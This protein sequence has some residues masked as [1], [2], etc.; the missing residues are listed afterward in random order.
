MYFLPQNESESYPASVKNLISGSRGRQIYPVSHN[1][2]FNYQNKVKLKAGQK[3]KVSKSQ[4]SHKKSSFL[5]TLVTS[6]VQFS[7]VVLQI[8][9]L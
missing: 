1:T 7:A 6:G 4:H 5:V 9:W 2:A 8:I 3:S